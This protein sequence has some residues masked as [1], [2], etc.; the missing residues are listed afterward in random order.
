MKAPAFQF[1]PSD[2]IMGTAE[3]TAEEVGGYIRGLCHQ[4]TKEGLPNNRK[5]L[6][7]M[8][9]VHG[10][11]LDTV[12]E[13]FQLH[14]DGRLKNFRLEKVREE[15]AEYRE[16]KSRAGK[17]G[18]NAKYGKGVAN[19]SDCQDSAN[20]LPQAN[21]LT[22]GQQNDS[23]SSSSSPSSL[24]NPLTPSSESFSDEKET[25]SL[26][27]DDN[28][29]A[30]KA[31]PEKPKEKSSAKKEKVPGTKHLFA[32]SAY[33][34]LDAF[35]AAFD[36]KA[37]SNIDLPAYHERIR[38]WSAAKGAKM[39]DWIAFSRNWIRNDNTGGQFKA[40]RKPSPTPPLRITQENDAYTVKRNV[41]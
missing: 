12:L 37:Y 7:S 34:D 17:A 41:A 1:Y 9:G 18:A 14:S 40:N 6:E 20:D 27:K 38:D 13:K 33:L 4:W 5:K 39:I 23:P 26:F 29:N 35:I 25:P 36:A 3:M 22:N 19:A 11:S 32:D 2:F 21:G 15:Q 10:E 24:S 8:L 30:L 31:A 16:K 28:S